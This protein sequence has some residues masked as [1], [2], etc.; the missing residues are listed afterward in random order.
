MGD[1]EATVCVDRDDH[2]T[3]SCTN[4]PLVQKKSSTSPRRQLRA[5]TCT[6]HEGENS[7]A[8]QLEITTEEIVAS[9]F[10]TNS[11]ISG[12]EFLARSILRGDLVDH[13]TST[14]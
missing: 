3:L 11:E 13:P 10:F 9:P 7:S 4:L 14:F 2:A 6:I 1:H 8:A 12:C 5:V